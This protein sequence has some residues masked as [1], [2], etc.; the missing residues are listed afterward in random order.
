MVSLVAIRPTGSIAWLRHRRS[1]VGRGLKRGLARWPDELLRR[2]RRRVLATTPPPRIQPLLRCPA[3]FSDQGIVYKMSYHVRVEPSGLCLSLRAEGTA[4]QPCSKIRA[5]R[6]GR[7]SPGGKMSGGGLHSVAWASV[8]TLIELSVIT[9]QSRGT[10]LL[11]LPTNE[12]NGCTC[13]DVP[14]TIS[15][16]HCG[17]SSFVR[18]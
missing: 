5:L 16:S 14:M 2:E 8:I 1:A 18:W 13:R 6:T 17:I 9:L 11:T 10:S 4:Q 7:S 15:R 3:L 12:A